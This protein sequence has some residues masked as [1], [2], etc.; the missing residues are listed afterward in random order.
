MNLDNHITG[1]DLPKNS[2][3][4]PQRLSEASKTLRQQ[5]VQARYGKYDTYA[6]FNQS[7][8][9]AIDDIVKIFTKAINTV[10]G[11]DRD[12]NEFSIYENKLQVLNENDLRAEQRQRI[13]ELIGKK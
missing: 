7:E 2:P 9:E 8:Q 5:I 11:E 3:D 12:M 6:K 10:I 4:D 1:N 13:A